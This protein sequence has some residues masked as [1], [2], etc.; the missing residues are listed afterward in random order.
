M[1]YRANAFNQDLTMWN[2]TYIMDYEYIF[3]DCPGMSGANNA[4][5]PIKFQQYQSIIPTQ[6]KPGRYLGGVAKKSRRASQK[7]SRKGRRTLK[8][9]AR[10]ITR[11][12]HRR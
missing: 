10:R 4:N 5:R 12:H 7:R 1:F 6:E 3:H 9:G 11:H 2:V 8:R